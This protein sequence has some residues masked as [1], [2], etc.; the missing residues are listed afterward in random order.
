MPPVDS[1]TPLEAPQQ[2][3]PTFTPSEALQ[4]AQDIAGR[5]RKIAGRLYIDD[6]P[7][8]HEK[9]DAFLLSLLKDQYP[10]MVEFVKSLKVWYG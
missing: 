5:T 4:K 7:E 10:E 6:A 3:E 1:Q 8:K 9:L 2:A